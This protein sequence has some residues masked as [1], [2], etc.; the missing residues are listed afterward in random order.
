MAANRT[1]LSAGYAL[2]KLLTESPTVAAIT[3]NVFPI[4]VDEA[5]LPYVAYRR[6]RMS[7]TAVKT[8]APYDSCLFE[9][10]CCAKSLDRP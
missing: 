10:L 1:S 2:Y 4:V 9:L 8:N 3:G 5:K 6:K 7:G